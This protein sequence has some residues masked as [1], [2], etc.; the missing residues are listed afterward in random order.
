M[1]KS[2]LEGD[3]LELVH[4]RR[5]ECLK[6]RGKLR[7]ALG[8]DYDIGHLNEDIDAL[9]GRIFP[10]AGGFNAVNNDRDW[11]LLDRYLAKAIVT[12]RLTVLHEHRLRRE[13]AQ[14]YYNALTGTNTVDAEGIYAA[15]MSI[16][17]DLFGHMTHESTSQRIVPEKAHVAVVWRAAIVGLEPAFKAG[18]TRPIHYGMSRNG[19]PHSTIYYRG[20]SAQKKVASDQMAVGFDPVCA[21]GGT[22]L[23]LVDELEK[24]GFSPSN[25]RL[26]SKFAAP[27][28]LVR[29]LRRRPNIAGFTIGRVEKGMDDHAYLFD[30]RVG[31]AGDL[32][33]DA[34]VR[35]LDAIREMGMISTAEATRLMER[36]A[37][38][39]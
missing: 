3:Q 7:L 33:R 2:V 9:L 26:A 21:T 13:Y 22:M 24:Q 31:D 39:V 20:E 8:T 11:A 5:S 32:S 29:V 25:I 30:M 34:L 15:D 36:F 23:D 37:S 12:E 4:K 16:L 28:G 27:E 17:G 10:E 6:D 35:R 14:L 1:F 19:T 18:I 38:G